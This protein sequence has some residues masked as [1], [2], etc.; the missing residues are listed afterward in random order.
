M[1]AQDA[2]T[3][4]LATTTAPALAASKTLNLVVLLPEYG[5]HNQDSRDAL[6]THLR[7]YDWASFGPGRFHRIDTPSEYWD[8]E[9]D[10][11]RGY[12]PMMASRAFYDQLHQYDWALV[13]QPDAIIFEDRL[14]Y[15]TS[16]DYDYIGAPHADQGR[17]PRGGNG[18]FSLRRIAA[19]RK[20]LEGTSGLTG[21][22]GINSYWRHVGI[23]E[24]CLWSEHPLIRPAPVEISYQFAW[25]TDPTWWWLAN[26]RQTPM[27]AHGWER[28]SP[29]FWANL[30]GVRAL[31]GLQPQSG[32]P[33]HTELPAD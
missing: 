9:P 20:A 15:F 6:W 30:G 14:P 1:L 24:D 18:G 16:L 31:A 26:N 25:E 32:E 7:G 28:H 13:Y 5:A 21:W 8:T 2:E 23:N 4:P 29:E 12:S 27:G 3:Q 33:P 22:A 10:G 19:F 11:R 17:W